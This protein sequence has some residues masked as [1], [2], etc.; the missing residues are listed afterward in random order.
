MKWMVK[1]QSPGVGRSHTLP[2]WDHV[3]VACS[4]RLTLPVWSTPLSNCTAT[5]PVAK[6][7]TFSDACFHAVHG[8]PAHRTLYV[9]AATSIAVMAYGSPAGAK[10]R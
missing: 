8:R 7:V 4:G 1:F 2:S 6:S 3:I 5:A 9:P 10:A